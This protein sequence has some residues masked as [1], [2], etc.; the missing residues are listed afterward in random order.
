MTSEVFSN[1]EHVMEVSLY[2]L[3]MGTYICNNKETGHE[4]DKCISQVMLML[5]SVSV[6]FV[7]H[8]VG[9]I[10]TRYH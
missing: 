3:H 4:Y 9:M 10:T 2:S 5:Q 8:R 6:S 7:Y 1:F